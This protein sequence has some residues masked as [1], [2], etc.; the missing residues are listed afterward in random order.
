MSHLKEYIKEEKEGAKT[1]K[2]LALRA[3]LEKKAFKKMSKDETSH[4]KKL[5]KME[6]AEKD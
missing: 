6:E 2:K 3:A 4:V 5:K 1:Y